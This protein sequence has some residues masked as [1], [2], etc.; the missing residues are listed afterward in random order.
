MFPN[1]YIH[2]HLYVASM[3]RKLASRATQK[4]I[5]ATPH[6][7][8]A[9]RRNARLPRRALENVRRSASDRPLET[10]AQ[11]MCVLYI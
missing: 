9:R 3:Q 1:D 4:I 2:I 10:D 8:S 5:R 6:R 11:R 7:D